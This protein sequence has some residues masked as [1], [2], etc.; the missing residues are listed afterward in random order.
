MSWSLLHPYSIPIILISSND[1]TDPLV[2]QLSPEKTHHPQDLSFLIRYRD[3]GAG[4]GNKTVGASNSCNS[5]K[6]NVARLTANYH[7]QV[8]ETTKHKKN[9]KK[10]KEKEGD[11]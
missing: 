8:K 5:P 4:E 11:N 7:F 1:P 2:P 10:K 9:R 3:G 6:P